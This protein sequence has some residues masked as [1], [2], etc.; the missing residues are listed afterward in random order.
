MPSR[1]GRPHLLTVRVALW[2]VRRPLSLLAM[3]VVAFGL[4]REVAPAAPRTTPVVVAAREVPAGRALRLADLRVRQV[5]TALVPGTAVSD[6]D[7]VLARRTAVSLPRG[8]AV[9]EPVLEGERFGVDPPPGT[10]I[11]A[12][13]VA[14]AA[15][16]GMLRAGDV[17]DLVTPTSTPAFSASPQ[18]AGSPAPPELLARRALVLGVGSPSED[19]SSVP[20]M[21]DAQHPTDLTVVVAVTP[22]EGRVLAAAATWGPL[23][24]VLVG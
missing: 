20:T 1:T 23:G 19:E 12:I 9:V 24:T 15:A 2:R 17:V 14:E 21:L 18:D 13:T 5:P 22:D 4:A 3:L 6:P 16:V 11:V 10:V 7:E 8:L